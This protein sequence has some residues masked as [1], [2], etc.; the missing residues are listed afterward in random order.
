MTTVNIPKL[1]TENVVV[2]GRLHTNK[3][4]QSEIVNDIPNKYRLGYTLINEPS[5]GSWSETHIPTAATA[6]M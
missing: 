3:I 5:Y 4:A 2:D 1:T 6:L